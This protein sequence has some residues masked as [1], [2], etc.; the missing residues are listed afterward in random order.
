MFIT[1][2]NWFKH[3]QFLVKMIDVYYSDDFQAHTMDPLLIEEWQKRD[4]RNLTLLTN[5]IHGCLPR[6]QMRLIERFVINLLG[7]LKFNLL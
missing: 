1:V 2:K 7:L 4:G 3:E 6:E 5:F